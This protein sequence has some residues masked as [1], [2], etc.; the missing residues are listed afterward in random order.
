[1]S[2]PTAHRLLRS[3]A[4][5]VLSHETQTVSFFFLL[6]F[7]TPE[8]FFLSLMSH[9]CCTLSHH[10]QW[11]ACDPAA[12]LIVPP[13]MLSWATPLCGREKQWEALQAAV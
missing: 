7:S 5:D 1:V 13:S 4:H 11:Q 9:S 2:P 10:H 12:S 3:E 6:L 8:L